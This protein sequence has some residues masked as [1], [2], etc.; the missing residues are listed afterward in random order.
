M[1]KMGIYRLFRGV[2]ESSLSLIIAMRMGTS[3]AAIGGER[4]FFKHYEGLGKTKSGDWNDAKATEK[5]QI[6][7]LSYRSL[8]TLISLLVSRKP[9]GF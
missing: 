5:D 4:A 8:R 6:Q 3:E 1:S 7:M 9:E 2:Q